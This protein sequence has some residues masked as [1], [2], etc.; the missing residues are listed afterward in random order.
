MTSIPLY[1]M[2]SRSILYKKTSVSIKELFDYPYVHFNGMLRHLPTWKLV[3]LADHPNRLEVDNAAGSSLMPSERGQY[4]PPCQSEAKPSDGRGFCF[5]PISDKNL[6]LNPLFCDPRQS[7]RP[8]KREREFIT[9]SAGFCSLRRTD[10]LTKRTV[11]ERTAHCFWRCPQ[12][13]FFY[14]NIFLA[15]NSFR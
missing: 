11:K 9:D 10:A 7:Y 6:Y 3:G 5:V 2:V 8:N 4:I 14:N 1:V 12:C 13:C 15:S